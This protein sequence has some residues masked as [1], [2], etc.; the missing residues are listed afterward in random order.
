MGIYNTHTSGAEFNEVPSTT[1]MRIKT[2][3]DGSAWARINWLNVIKDATYFSTANNA[4]TGMPETKYCHAVN[5]F[6]MMEY[7]DNFATSLVTIKNLAPAIEGT[8]GFGSSSYASSSSTRLYGSSSFQITANAS[9]AETTVSSSVKM[10]FTSG[11]IYY[12]TYRIFQTSVVGTSEFFWPVVA[13]G[14]HTGKAAVANT[15]TKVS[16]RKSQTTSTT[17]DYTF[18]FDFNNV[19]NAGTMLFDGLVVVDLTE[20]FGAG[21]EPSQAWCDANIPY[22]LG[23][24]TID[25]SSAGYKRWEFMLTYPNLSQTLYNRWSQTGSPNE[26]APGGYKRITTAWTAHAGPIRNNSSGTT[27]WNCDNEG[28]TTW[29]AAIGQTQAWTSTQ[30]IPAA[31]GNPQT[32]TEL[33]VRVDNLTPINKVT[34]HSENHITGGQLYEY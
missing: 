3:E 1:L 17:G 12:V 11:H 14:S 28:S 20:D 24:K 9:A 31:D 15:W 16:N 21:K 25:A 26:A 34:V 2:L 32:E 13:A 22:F 5:R 6:S 27:V 7:I 10:H 30:A 19:N 29:F 8:T 23:E 18:R 33:W 4:T